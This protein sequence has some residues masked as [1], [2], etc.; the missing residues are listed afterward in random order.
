MESLSGL[1]WFA[2]PSS[3]KAGRKLIRIATL[4]SLWLGGNDVTREVESRKA[5]TSTLACIDT[6]QMIDGDLVRQQSESALG[7][8]YDVLAMNS[9]RGMSGVGGGFHVGTHELGG[10]SGGGLDN[11]EKE[12][13]A[14]LKGERDVTVVS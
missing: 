9:L 10:G 4:E 8:S 5:V 3:S 7:S 14:A 12:F 6:L 1:L 13:L 2:P 11:M